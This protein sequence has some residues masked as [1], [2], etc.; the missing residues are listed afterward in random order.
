MSRDHFYLNNDTH[1]SSNYKNARYLSNACAGISFH[2]MWACH[3]PVSRI[4]AAG[5][6]AKQLRALGANAGDRAGGFMC[7]EMQYYDRNDD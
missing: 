5:C 3:V 7:D 6:S 2:E 1:T 4:A